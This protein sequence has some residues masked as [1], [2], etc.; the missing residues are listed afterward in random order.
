MA[1]SVLTGIAGVVGLLSLLLTWR[2]GAEEAGFTG[3]RLFVLNRNQA[4]RLSD[5]LSSYAI[6]TVGVVGGALIVISLLLLMPTTHNP[7]GVAALLL[8]LFSITGVVWYVFAKWGVA[9]AFSGAEFGFFCFVGSGV[10]GLI[11]SM[12]ALSSE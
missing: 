4:S 3:W 6:L 1:A 8:S 7:A 9:E 11:G 10:L 2:R 5:F 12:V